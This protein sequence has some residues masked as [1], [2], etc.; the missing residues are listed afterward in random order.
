MGRG[1]STK[2]LRGSSQI[3]GNS[4]DGAHKTSVKLEPDL[5]DERSENGISHAH[6]DGIFADRITM[7]V[8]ENSSAP[9]LASSQ[10]P[11]PSD[12]M[13]PPPSGHMIINMK[14]TITTHGAH[15]GVIVHAGVQS[16]PGSSQGQGSQWYV[17]SQFPQIETPGGTRTHGVAPGT[18][19]E[20]LT[21]SWPALHIN[22]TATSPQPEQPRHLRQDRSPQ[23]QRMPSPPHSPV[24]SFTGRDSPPDEFIQ[25]SK[26]TLN[27]FNP[28]DPAHPDRVV[29]LPPA[30]VPSI[31]DRPQLLRV[32]GPGYEKWSS[33]RTETLINDRPVHTQSH[34][35]K[36]VQWKETLVDGVPPGA[37]K[38]TLYDP[39]SGPR[40]PFANAVTTP[41]LP[42]SHQYQLPTVNSFDERILPRPSSSK[43]P[44]IVQSP[45]EFSQVSHPVITSSQED[46]SRPP[47]PKSP[48]PPAPTTCCPKIVSH[49][50]IPDTSLDYPPAETPILRPPVYTGYEQ[51]RRPPTLPPPP[52]NSYP[53]PCLI[54]SQTSPLYVEPNRARHAKP[55]ELSPANRYR[56]VESSERYRSTRR[57]Q[58]S[59]RRR[60]DHHRDDHER[61]RHRSESPAYRQ[62]YTSGGYGAG[63]IVSPGGYGATATVS[64]GGYGT[65]PNVLPGERPT[66][67][68]SREIF[69]LYQTRDVMQNVVAQL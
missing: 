3:S 34:H 35:G 62:R 63:A 2:A 68:N 45:S 43:P 28:L 8:K 69:R 23:P 37:K 44:Y 20:N 53:D 22:T 11:P 1:L 65:D 17:P 4:V 57:S 36:A 30:P 15:N 56:S 54:R 58:S 38:V 60:R 14:T 46:L 52:V 51:V 16:G 50:A 55:A 9:E 40:S 31:D 49:P 67:V 32:N 7:S 25:P 48:I 59:H 33:Q 39:Y 29:A 12:K 6:P 10:V 5:V 61:Q 18:S 19:Q 42:S 41:H 27:V 13:R 64:P 47:F 66:R 24:Y 26:V 21:T